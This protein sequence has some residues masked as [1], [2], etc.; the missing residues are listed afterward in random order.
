MKCCAGVS[1]PGF[2]ETTLSPNFL[3]RMEAR[4]KVVAVLIALAVLLSSPYIMTSVLVGTTSLMFLLKFAPKNWGLGKRLAIP[5]YI[6][7]LV[8]VTQVFWTGNSPI[9]AIGPFL[10][11][12]EGLIQGLTLG[13]RI[14]AGNLLMLLLAATTSP[15]ELL[16]TAGWLRLPDVLVEI[17]NLMYRYLFLLLDEA[18]TVRLAQQTRLGYSHWREGLRSTSALFA[19]VLIRTYDRANRVYQAMTARGYTGEM[20]ALEKLKGKRFIPE[21]IALSSLPISFW[22]GGYLGIWPF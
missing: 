3:F 12:K 19:V 8:M 7:L 21:V 2:Q 18:Q 10:A 16:A 6:S 11:K 22:F 1:L 17:A 13:S 4:A 20:P 9:F 5:F 15:G 14:M